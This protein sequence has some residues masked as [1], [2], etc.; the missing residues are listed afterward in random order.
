[1]FE[2]RLWVYGGFA[3][4]Q[5]AEGM[6]HLDLRT[7]QPTWEK[8]QQGGTLPNRQLGKHKSFHGAVLAA[9]GHMMITF[10]VAQQVNEQLLSA[11]GSASDQ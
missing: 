10:G 2:D 3:N 1:V 11:T 6:Y 7:C 4:H 8:V 9:A 5:D